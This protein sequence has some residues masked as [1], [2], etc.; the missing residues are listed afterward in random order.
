MLNDPLA[1][2]REDFRL[3]LVADKRDPQQTVSGGHRLAAFAFFAAHPLASFQTK[4]RVGKD[5]AAAAGRDDRH[6]FEIVYIARFNAADRSRRDRAGEA[7][8][9]R[10]A[11]LK[12][13]IADVVVAEQKPA[14]V[15]RH[16][17]RSVVRLRAGLMPKGNRLDARYFP[18]GGH[19][20]VVGTVAEGSRDWM[21]TRPDCTLSGTFHGRRN[22]EV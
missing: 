3:Q 4:R 9:G 11:E 1:K 14:V 10:Q 5:Q 12:Q 19:S 16:D 6:S 8:I 18:G 13:G 7:A 20:S 22:G 15:D 21:L 2:F 17:F